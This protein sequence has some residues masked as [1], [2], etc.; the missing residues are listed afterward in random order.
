MSATTW[1]IIAIIGFSLAGIALIIAIFM[2]VK[3]N[4]PSIIGDLSGKT[5]AREIKAMR[6]FNNAN[7]DR[8]FRPSKVNLERG[9]LTEKVEISQDN[10]KAMAE[11][12][13][14]KRLDNIKS[15]ELSEK[16]TYSSGSG[17]GTVGLNDFEINPTEA[18]DEGNEPTEMLSDGET[19]VLNEN[20]TEV[21]NENATEVLSNDTT[22]LNG[23]TVLG[24]TEKL[25]EESEVIPVPFKITK[26]EIVIHT[27]EVIK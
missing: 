24:K 2:F 11:A 12:H 8:R 16:K 25:T 4:I 26:S 20:A 10:R 21:L 5:V 15:G 23:T 9:V 22:V 3:M 13:A 27:D 19:E 6:E 17:S 18:L 7:G 14:S 1:L